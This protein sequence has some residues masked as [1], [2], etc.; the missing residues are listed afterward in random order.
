VAKPMP[1]L[2]TKPSAV[3]NHHSLGYRYDVEDKP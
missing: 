2:A 1:V 3:L